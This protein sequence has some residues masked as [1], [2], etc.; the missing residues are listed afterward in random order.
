MPSYSPVFSVPLI[1]WTT[2]APNTSFLVPDGYTAVVRQ[3]TI[4]C[5]A[6]G[7]A[8]GVYIADSEIAPPCWIHYVTEFGVLVEDQL[9]G[10]W[11]V[12]GGGLLVLELTD[13][14]SLASAYVGGYLLRNSLS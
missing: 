14:A 4:L 2:A 9:E 1:Q 11:T 13:F 3:M 12:P 7:V 10:R 6:G 8:G 5:E